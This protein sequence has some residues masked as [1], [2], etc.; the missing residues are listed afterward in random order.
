MSFLQFSSKRKGIRAWNF[1]MMIRK[2]WWFLWYQN[3]NNF[4]KNEKK[5]GPGFCK[6][7]LGPSMT[8]LRALI[9]GA[10]KS[11]IHQRLKSAKCFKGHW[12]LS[13]KI[14]TNPQACLILTP[15]S[16]VFLSVAI[17][18]FVGVSFTLFVTCFI[19]DVAKIQLGNVRP[20]LE[21]NCSI[22]HTNRYLNL[23][24]MNHLLWWVFVNIGNS[25]KI[26]P[27]RYLK[28]KRWSD[29]YLEPRK[30]RVA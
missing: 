12:A 4:E 9:F 21:R 23:H 27:I 25:Y 22:N 26:M 30:Y 10:Q 13:L 15:V 29:N 19:T 24:N 3:R 28:C 8:K 14:D 18:L 5:K 6:G 16:F 7:H 2:I 1:R 17:S 20:T 11:F